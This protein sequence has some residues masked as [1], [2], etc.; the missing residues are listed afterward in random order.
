MNSGNNNGHKSRRDT[1]EIYAE[2]IR[3]AINGIRKT[4]LMSRVGLSSKQFKEHTEFLI[5]IGLLEVKTN[6]T[7]ASTSNG[8]DY[9]NAYRKA[10]DLLNGISVPPRLSIMTNGNGYQVKPRA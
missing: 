3:N 7:Y 6:G 8:I 5:G 2:I 4:Y 9:S 1:K 10:I